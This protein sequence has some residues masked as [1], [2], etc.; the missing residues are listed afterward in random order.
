M[1]DFV[2]LT[3]SSCDLPSKLADDLGVYAIPLRLSIKGNEYKNY[4]D[5]REIKFGE[6]YKMIRGGEL[7]KT[8]AI[9]IDTF[10]KEMEKPLK[11]DKDIL[12]LSFSSGLSNTYNAAQIAL[13]ELLEKYPERKIYVVDTLCASLGQG[14]LVYLAA[15]EKEKGKSIDEVKDF[16]EDNKLNICHMFTVDDL[17]HLKRG[18]RISSTV[19]FFGT[20]LNI[21]PVLHVD[22]EGKLVNIS[23]ARG[24][25][26]SLESLVNYMEKSV[27][28]PGNQ[29]IFISHGD[30]YD[31]AK[32]VAD[33]VKERLKVKEVI[34]NYVGPVIGAHSGP[35][36]VALFFYGSQR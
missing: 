1:S 29:T 7:A 16:C 11:R 20:L 24:R 31:D 6:F 27:I 3:D 10:L 26:E 2:I 19:A 25:R 33:L 9:N 5:E 34:I 15:K 4:L 28:D 36:T 35:G 23:K 22:N 12:Y 13:K 14:M 8:T 21:K 18:G 17:N 32:Y 30:C